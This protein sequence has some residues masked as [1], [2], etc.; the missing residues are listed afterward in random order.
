[1]NEGMG[2]WDRWASYFSLLSYFFTERP[3]SPSDLFA[4]SSS[5]FSKLFS[6]QPL[7]WA[8]SALSCLPAGFFVASATQVFS[9]RKCPAAI[10]HSARVALWSRTAFRAAAAPLML[11]WSCLR[12]AV[13]M[14]FVTDSCKPALQEERGTKSTN[15]RAGLK[16]DMILR[17]SEVFVDSYVGSGLQSG[18]HFIL[19]TPS[20]NS[21][22]NMQVFNILKCKLSSRHGPVHFLRTTFAERAPNPRKRRLYFGDH[23][24]HITEKRQGF[25]SKRIDTR[26]FTHGVAFAAA[27]HRGIRSSSC[28][29][30]T[31]CSSLRAKLQAGAWGSE[32]QVVRLAALR[33]ERMHSVDQGVPSCPLGLGGTH[34]AQLGCIFNSHASEFRWH[35]DVVDMMVEMVTMTI[36]CNS[37]VSYN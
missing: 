19:P 22:P 9:S 14:Q 18:A 28:P 36:V 21:A 32:C 26:E 12:A 4:E 2:G 8:T 24:S 15:V 6:E 25:A 30:R 20:S 29:G 35:D 27:R 10:P 11:F 23:R 33:A 31:S 1:M 37:E 3:L 34:F 17:Y 7:I 5:L 16:M 13:P